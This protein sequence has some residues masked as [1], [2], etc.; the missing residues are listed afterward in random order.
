MALLEALEHRIYVDDEDDDKCAG[1]SIAEIYEYFGMEQQSDDGEDTLSTEEED[2]HISGDEDAIIEDDAEGAGDGDSI[3]DDDWLFY[4]SEGGD[5]GT[6]E[7][8]GG[9]EEPDI[10]CIYYHFMRKIFIRNLSRLLRPTILRM[11]STMCQ[12]PSP[13]IHLHSKIGLS[14]TK[15]S[16][17]ILKF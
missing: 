15:L 5:E 3:F 4:I 9:E 17:K 11:V 8:S 1:M 6:Q 2:M 13:K 7:F 16:L 10:V 12:S 14:F